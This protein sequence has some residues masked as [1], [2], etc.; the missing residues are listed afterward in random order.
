MSA[1]DAH[2]LVELQ[3]KLTYQEDL[4][5][6]LNEEVTAQ[7]AALQDAQRAIARLERTVRGLLERRSPDASEG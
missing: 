2:T 3:M 1:E 5:Q 6:T 4:I 7:S